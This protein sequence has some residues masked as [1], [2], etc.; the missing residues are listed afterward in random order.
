MR[1]TVSLWIIEFCTLVVGLIAFAMF[2]MRLANGKYAR[3]CIWAAVSA[4]CCGTLVLIAP[5]VF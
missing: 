2:Y 4:L 3:A 1:F 5:G